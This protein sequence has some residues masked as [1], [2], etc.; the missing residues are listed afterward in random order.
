VE[1]RIVGFMQDDTGDWVAQLECFHRQHVRHNPPF[2]PAPWV[3][4]DLARS[5]R[6]GTL[7]D[8]PLCDRAELPDD[9]VVVRTTDRWNERTMPAGLRRGHR[10]ASGMWGRLR[11]VE[12]ELRFVAQT[13][14]VI[15]VIIVADAP[16][17]IPPVVVHEVEPKGPV[18]FFVEFL[19]PRA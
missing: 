9:L 16:Q 5:Q 8:C 19:R 18:R 12:G 14:P 4:D 11:V 6:I 7:L 2:R 1:R 15:D 10:V 13:Q 3:L 17:A